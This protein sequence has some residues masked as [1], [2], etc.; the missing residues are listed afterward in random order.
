[1]PR[2]P[3]PAPQEARPCHSQQP[4]AAPAQATRPANAS[5]FEA[6]R[7]EATTSSQGSFQQAIPRSSQGAVATFLTYIFGDKY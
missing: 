5:T 7:P 1:M 2:A 3:T 4:L 6:P